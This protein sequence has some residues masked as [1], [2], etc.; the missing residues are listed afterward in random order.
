MAECPSQKLVKVNLRKRPSVLGCEIQSGEVMTP[1][2]RSEN[3][4]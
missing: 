4:L 2:Y 3:L 1:D